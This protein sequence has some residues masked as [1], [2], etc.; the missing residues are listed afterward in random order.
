[1]NHAVVFSVLEVLSLFWPQTVTKEIKITH[2]ETLL[3]AEIY[4]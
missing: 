3:K 1:M 4:I 2:R